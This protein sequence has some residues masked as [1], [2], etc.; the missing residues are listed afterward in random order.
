MGN[1]AKIKVG[2]IM[3]AS[4]LATVSILSLP[5]RPDVPG[6]IL[7]AMGGRNINIEFVVHNVD[8]DG[9]GNMTFCID[10]KNLEAALEVL[11]AVKPLIEAKGISYH[12]NV[13]TVSVFGPHF[14]ERPMISGLMF[15]ALGTAGINVMAIS[16]SI[17]SCSCVI[18]GD[19]IEDAL[20]ALHETFDAPHQVIKFA[21]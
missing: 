9:N 18:E 4:G 10:Q 1:E 21:P 12:P 5:D 7:H 11:E 20:R 16:T 14:R 17:S 19:Q 6:M 3:A 13:A 2:G 15:N 8:I